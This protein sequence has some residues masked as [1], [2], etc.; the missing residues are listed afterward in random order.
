MEKHLLFKRFGGKRLHLGV[1][2]S[3]AAFKVADLVHRWQDTGAAVSATLTEAASK[4][5]TP[6]TFEALGAS[7]VYRAMFSGEAPF[8][9]LEPGQ[10]AHAMVIAPAT[11]D[12]MARLAHGRACDMLSAQALAFDGPVV[13]APAMNPRMWQ[14]P[15]TQDNAA[16]LRER[17]FIF[18]GPDSGLVAC[19]DEGQGRLADLRLIYLA[20]LKALTPQDMEGETVMVTLGPTRE[21]WDDVR[22]WTNGSTGT[23]GASIAVAAW[24]RGAEVHAV[25]GPL[26]AEGLWL[27]DD[28][29]FHRH[30]VVSAAQ[31]LEKSSEIWPSAT[32]GVFTAA[33]AD[34]RPVPYGGGKFKK[35]KAADGLHVDFLPN[36]DILRTLA[37]E[38]SEG[39]VVVGF[40]AEAVPDADALAA[41]VQYKLSYKGADMIVGNRIADGFG[42]ASN[43][44]YVADVQGREEQWPDM[45]K[46]QVAWKILDW[47]RT[48]AV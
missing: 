47:A 14:N 7:P 2:G 3:I 43:R 22:F 48:L 21:T 44:V 38:R 19:H 35:D 10:T 40:A 31:M 39:Q 34:F 46:P 24:L 15:A 11:A 37:E 30:D 29:A 45:A 27:P 20:G 1:C 8:E 42:R 41:A 9:H 18:V 28:P 16:L 23:M 12:I 26:G 32:M 25:C 13:I 36:A 5:V 6:L 17:G 33:V 4:F